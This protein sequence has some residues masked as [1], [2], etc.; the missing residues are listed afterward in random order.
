MFRSVL[1]WMLTAAFLV[2]FPVTGAGQCP[3][4][5]VKSLRTRPPAPT[6]PIPPPACKCC[7]DAGVQNATEQP[8][9]EPRS[10]PEPPEGSCG[11][12]VVS[13]AVAENGAGERSAVHGDPGTP[14]AEPTTARRQSAGG[15]PLDATTPA[16][17]PRPG[18]HL[19]RYAHAFRC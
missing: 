7:R 10:L 11:H 5:S 9:G 17:P 8:A 19:I 2:T 12:C 3:C 4:R 15:F 16:P 14:A 18:P 6:S 1:A 13:D